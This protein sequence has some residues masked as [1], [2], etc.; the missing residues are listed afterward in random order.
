MCRTVISI[1][2][3][4]V[5]IKKSEA[6]VTAFYNTFILARRRRQTNVEVRAAL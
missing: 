3:I 4:H 5:I 1:Y 6:L 2:L